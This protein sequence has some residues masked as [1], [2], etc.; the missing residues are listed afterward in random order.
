MALR[1]T[2]PRRVA[3]TPKG[4]RMSS[5]TT[6]PS[7]TPPMSNALGSGIHSN[8]GVGGSSGSVSK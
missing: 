4:I 8:S 2:R 3:P 5:D 6:S 1:A 7:N